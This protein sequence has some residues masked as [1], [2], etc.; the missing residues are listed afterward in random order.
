MTIENRPNDARNP[1]VANADA[2]QQ[3]S[4]S[5]ENRPVPLAQWREAQRRAVRYL[6]EFGLADTEAAALAAAA[7]RTGVRRHRAS[8]A[9]RPSAAVMA[10]LES[11]LTQTLIGRA[12]FFSASGDRVQWTRWRAFATLGGLYHS[13]PAAAQEGVPARTG[14]RIE[15][16]EAPALPSSPLI[17]RCSLSPRPLERNAALRLWRWSG[18]IVRKSVAVLRTCC[19]GAR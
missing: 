2:T 9:L 14:R 15:V 11:E 18:R 16:T 3:A 19:C 8:P 1:V 12:G 13:T 17:R 6:Q 7:L 10:A 4:T 5:A